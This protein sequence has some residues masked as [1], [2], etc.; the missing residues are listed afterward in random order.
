MLMLPA[1]PFIHHRNLQ[2]V[3]Q[4]NQNGAFFRRQRS[5]NLNPQRSLDRLEIEL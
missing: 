3:M 1:R 4:K 5:E 2:H